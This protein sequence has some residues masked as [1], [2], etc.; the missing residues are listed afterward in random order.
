MDIDDKL[1]DHIAY[2]ARLSFDGSDREA[3]KRDMS[4]ITD[5]IG[6]LSEINTD[7]VEPLIFMSEEQNVLREDEVKNVVS[8]EDAMKNAPK[9]DADYFRIPKVLNRD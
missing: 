6:K 7:D 3:I 8:H 1:V 5:F 4:N 2:L 9:K